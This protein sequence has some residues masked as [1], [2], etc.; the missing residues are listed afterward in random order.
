MELNLVSYT[1]YWLVL[2]HLVVKTA[3][4][5]WCEN[6]GSLH[7]GFSFKHLPNTSLD[8]VPWYLACARPCQDCPQ[9]DYAPVSP[10]NSFFVPQDGSPVTPSISMSPPQNQFRWEGPMKL[11]TRGYLKFEPVSIPS[12]KSLYIYFLKSPSLSLSPGDFQFSLQ[13]ESGVAALIT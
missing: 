8:V 2:A 11:G 1:F 12:C 10:L 7:F 9:H 4:P 6:W 13:S 3:S 5:R